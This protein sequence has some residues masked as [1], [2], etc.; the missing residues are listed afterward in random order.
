M[1]S[2]PSV[3]VVILNW[4]G[5]QLLER[6]IP[7]LLLNTPDWVQ[8]II[9]DNA[10]TD[11]SVEFLKAHY[12]ALKIIEN[13]H[14]YGYAAGYNN[15]LEQVEATYFVLLNS[16]VEVSP[17]WIEPVITY[18]EAH[19]GTAVCQP[20]IRSWEKKDYFEYAGAAGGYMDKFGYFFC[21]GRLFDS[22]EKDLG[23]YDEPCEIFWASGA[24]FFIR[25]DWFRRAGGFDAMLFAHME[26]IDLCWRLKL[27]GQ[28]IA[29]VPG[30]MIYHVGGGTLSKLS[31]RKT[32][33]NFRNNLILLYKNLESGKRMGMIF[34]RFFLDF[35]AWLRFMFLFQFNHAFAINRAHIG[36]L[37]GLSVW[38]ETRHKA[39]LPGSIPKVNQLT[40]FYKGSI[41]ADYFLAGITR[42][43]ELKKDRF[44]DH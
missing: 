41:A 28:K 3:A 17:N 10:S 23:Q 16:D 13:E 9:G 6:F 22:L 24:A 20:K 27:L 34:M 12:P 43:S 39:G 36:F 42:F 7:P 26:E 44:S 14:N 19:P 33:L 21:R 31:P 37:A 29:Y 30:S 40:G 4:N 1:T 35:L 11:G 15:V 5:K 25:S 8:I 38:K 18:M 32:Y 2:Y